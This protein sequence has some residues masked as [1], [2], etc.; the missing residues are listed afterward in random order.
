MR[1]PGLTVSTVQNTAGPSPWLVVDY[2]QRP[3]IEGLFASLSEDASAITYQVEHTPDNPNVLTPFTGSRTTTVL[4]LGF[5]KAHGLVAG[6]SVVIPPPSAFAGTY[7]VASAPSTTSLTVTVPNSG[8]AVDVPQAS[9]A[10]LRVF[11]DTVLT[12]KTAKAY[13]LNAV[14]VLASRVNA[15]A[16]TT[17]IVTLQVVQGHARG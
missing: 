8:P 3:F 13:A 16:V 6:D 9:A 2:L 1:A 4:T 11:I 17:G 5:A 7:P 14:P 12:A 10:L 15:T